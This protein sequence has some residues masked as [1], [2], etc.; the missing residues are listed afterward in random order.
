MDLKKIHQTIKEIYHQ[1]IFR[2]PRR[3]IEHK[4][5]LHDL[6]EVD[7]ADL[8][9]LADENDG[10]KYII[11]LVNTFSKYLFTAAVKDL[12]APTVSNVVDQMLD[13]IGRPIKNLYSDRGVEYKNRIFAALTKR[14]GIN[15]YFSESVK[16]APTVERFAFNI[17]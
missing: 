8:S 10:Y 15:H 6:Y 16:K 7:S 5:D 3:R 2:F 4:N 1:A 17:F 11:V 12:K 13:K 9:S 14:R